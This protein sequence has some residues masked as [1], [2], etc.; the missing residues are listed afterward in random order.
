[1]KDFY[2][3]VRVAATAVIF[4]VWLLAT[5]RA[6]GGAILGM[7]VPVAAWVIFIIGAYV[8]FVIL[9]AEVFK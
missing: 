3:A 4:F 9:I 2:I 1:M 5:L 8:L 7:S 6:L